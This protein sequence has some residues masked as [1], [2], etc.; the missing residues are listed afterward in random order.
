MTDELSREEVL[1]RLAEQDAKWPEE[2][3]L[4]RLKEHPEATFLVWCYRYG[5]VMMAK[6]GRTAG[7]DE[8]F[9]DWQDPEQR[10]L[11]EEASA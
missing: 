1:A 5:L 6:V 4:W 7:A 11:W 10:D 3:T 9:V 8:L 2:D